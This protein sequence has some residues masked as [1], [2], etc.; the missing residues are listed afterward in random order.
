MHWIFNN[1]ADKLNFH[2]RSKK[3][4]C[5]EACIAFCVPFLILKPFSYK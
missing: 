1:S 4:G 5:K 2:N 3:A